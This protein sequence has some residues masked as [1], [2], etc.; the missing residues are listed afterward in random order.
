MLII[1]AHL[2]PYEQG[3]FKKRYSTPLGTRNALDH[4]EKDKCRQI[5]LAGQAFLG[6][7]IHG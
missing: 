5:C 6:G 3:I 4:A 2:A 1:L 7:L